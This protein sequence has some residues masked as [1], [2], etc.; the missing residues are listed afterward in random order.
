MTPLCLIFLTCK[1]DPYLLYHQGLG[2]NMTWQSVSKQLLLLVVVGDT[3]VSFPLLCTIHPSPVAGK[4]FKAQLRHPLI[5]EALPGPQ[6]ASLVP[7]NTWFPPLTLLASLEWWQEPHSFCEC[8][9]VQGCQNLRSAG[10]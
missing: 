10:P 8:P 4:V 7:T 3:L 1:W 6:G 5:Q 9:A 2:V